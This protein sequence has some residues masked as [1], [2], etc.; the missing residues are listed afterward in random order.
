M[1]GLESLDSGRSFLVHSAASRIRRS[2][3]SRTARRGR[4]RYLSAAAPVGLAAVN[5]TAW[6]RISSRA[7]RRFAT[8]W[9]GGGCACNSAGTTTHVA[10]STGSETSA[11]RSRLM[12]ESSPTRG[13]RNQACPP[14]WMSVR[15]RDCCVERERDVFQG[16]SRECR[17]VGREGARGCAASLPVGVGCWHGGC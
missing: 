1:L 8:S 16:I 5:R 9:S 11:W 15:E 13:G 6:M 10:D 2:G 14:H 4:S 12:C 3:S 17:S 7:V